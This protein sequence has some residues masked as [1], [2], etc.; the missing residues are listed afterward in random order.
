MPLC[1]KWERN[2]AQ[3]APLC[4]ITVEPK[5]FKRLHST[6]RKLYVKTQPFP[7]ERVEHYLATALKPDG[8]TDILREIAAWT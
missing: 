3:G 1:E 4:V 5:G 8:N 7:K 6:E 2:P